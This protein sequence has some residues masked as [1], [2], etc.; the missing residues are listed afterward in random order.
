M[1]VSEAVEVVE[2]HCTMGL[3]DKAAQEQ[4]ADM[5]ERGAASVVDTAT[6]AVAAH[7]NIVSIPKWNDALDATEGAGEVRDTLLQVAKKLRNGESFK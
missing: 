7:L 3:F 6:V 4:F 2:T 5:Y 1:K